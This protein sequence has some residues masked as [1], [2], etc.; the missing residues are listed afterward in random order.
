MLMLLFKSRS[1]SVNIP[2]ISGDV[3][4]SQPIWICLFVYLFGKLEE[5]PA[6]VVNVGLT[7]LLQIRK[8]GVVLI[9]DN[10]NGNK[11]KTAYN[12]LYS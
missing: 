9:I 8:A 11:K 1:L 12:L 5:V 4:A 6:E 3:V 7:H 2:H 10:C